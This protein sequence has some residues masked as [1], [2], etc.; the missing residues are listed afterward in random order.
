MKNFFKTRIGRAVGVAL[1]VAVIW[2]ICTP[3]FDT[4]FRVGINWQDLYRY[5]FEPIVIGVLVGVFEYF[6]QF[7]NKKKKSKKD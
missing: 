5:V 1:S 2:A 6:F 7:S 3:L 4:L